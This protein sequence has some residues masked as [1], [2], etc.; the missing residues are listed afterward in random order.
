MRKPPQRDVQ[1]GKCHGISWMGMAWPL[2]D[3]NL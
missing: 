3:L 1:F 2:N